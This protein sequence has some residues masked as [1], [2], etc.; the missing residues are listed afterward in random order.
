[1]DKFKISVKLHCPVK[2]VFTGWLNN[3]THSDFTGGASA[4]IDPKEGGKFSAWDGYITG[5]NVEIF[6]YKRIV[7]KWRT[8]DFAES[9]EDSMLELFFTYKDNHT[10]ITFTHSNIPDGQGNQYKKG[11]KEHYFKYMKKYF[12]K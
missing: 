6:P 2:D 8:T 4:K 3:Q 10:L 12:E 1:M 5:S 7:Q 11:W 9:D